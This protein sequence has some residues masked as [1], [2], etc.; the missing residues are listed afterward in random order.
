LRLD[1]DWPSKIKINS[2]T[3]CLR[4]EGH[5]RPYIMNYLYQKQIIR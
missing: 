3:I 1:N 5:S 4:I 2:A